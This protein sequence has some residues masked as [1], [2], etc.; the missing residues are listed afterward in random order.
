MNSRRL[1]SC[2]FALLFAAMPAWAQAPQPTTVAV[3]DADIQR[4]LVTRVDA[5]K[6]ATGIVLGVIGPQGRKLYTYGT[7]AAGDPRPVDG[8]TVF[9]IGSVTKVFTALLLADMARRGEVALDDPA[10]KYLPADAVHLPMRG[11][12]QISLADLATHT[13]GLPLRPANL[14]SKDPDNKYAGYSVDLLYQ[15]LSSY[16]L[17]RDIGSQ[18]EYSNVGYGLLGLALSHRAGRSYA[19]LVRGRITAPLHLPDTRLDLSPSMKRRLAT[20]YNAD[21][22][23]VPHWD[24]GALESAGSLRSTANDL[25]SFTAAFLGEPPTALS[26]AMRA[27]LQTRRPG[28]M[29]PSDQ[30]ALA[31]N[32]LD[33]NGHEIAWKNGSVSGF[34]TFI[35]FDAK[36]RLGVVALANA[37]TAAGADD[38]ALHL[39]GAS[40]PVDLHVPTAHHEIAADPAVLERYVGRYRYSDTDILTVSRDGARLYGQEPGQD[41]FELHAEGPH[42]FFLKEVDAQVTFESTG[43]APASAAV[44]HQ[45]GQDQRGLRIE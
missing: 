44:W 4:M 14:V 6:Q 20:G 24:M 36:A 42:D 45:G 38:I 10:M 17:P 1:Q 5:Q 7:V 43:D 40:L 21:L 2:A 29:P 33:D 18:Y 41:K 39:L 28:G 9:D 35:G 31:W 3:S 30:I 22:Q 27:M 34:R 8:N 25:L 12:R 23:P 37:Q 11:G 15:F 13:S 19:E 32:I 16:T 26:P